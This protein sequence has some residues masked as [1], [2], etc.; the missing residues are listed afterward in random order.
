MYEKTYALIPSG[1]NTTLTKG[2]SG[3]S[4]LEG[5]AF[6]SQ[7]RGAMDWVETTSEHFFHEQ[8][9]QIIFDGDDGFGCKVTRM[10]EVLVV[11]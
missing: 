11:A 4:G 7:R 2:G 10:N 9:E 5:T 6:H 8:L 1:R 3:S